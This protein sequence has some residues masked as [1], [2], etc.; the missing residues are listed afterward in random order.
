MVLYLTNSQLARS[1]LPENKEKLRKRLDGPPTL[2][3]LSSQEQLLDE[4]NSFV[5]KEPE[6]AKHVFK[7]SENFVGPGELL[8]CYL[9]DNVHINHNK[10]PDLLLDGMPKYECKSAKFPQRGKW[11][12]FAIDFT[13]GETGAYSLFDDLHRYRIEHFTFNGTDIPGVDNGSVYDLKA[14]TLSYIKNTPI[15]SGDVDMTYAALEQR[16][17]SATHA[18]YIADKDFLLFD[19]ATARLMYAGPL[20]TEQLSV[21]RVHRQVYAGIKMNTSFE[22]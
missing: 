11:K 22:K 18:N 8:L 10:S 2:G 17:A 16:W 7:L 19:R 14:N 20:Y 5:A 15:R 3:R 1:T 13:L 4:Y 6:F 9:Y 12:G 21:Y